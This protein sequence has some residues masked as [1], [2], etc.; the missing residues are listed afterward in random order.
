LRHLARNQGSTLIES[1]QDEEPH[2]RDGTVVWSTQSRQALKTP[3]PVRDADAGMMPGI[4]GS[5]LGAACA[6]STERIF[7]VTIRQHGLQETLRCVVYTSRL[8]LGHCRPMSR[9]GAEQRGQDGPVACELAK[10]GSP[11]IYRRGGRRSV[12]MKSGRG[13]FWGAAQKMSVE[14][15]RSKN[16][17]PPTR[18]DGSMLKL[19]QGAKR[20]PRGML[21][22]KDQREIAAWPGDSHGARLHLAAAHLPSP[23]VADDEFLGK[24]ADLSGRTRRFKLL[25]SD[26]HAIMCMVTRSGRP[27][28]W[29]L[30]FN[31]RGWEPKAGT[32]GRPLSLANHVRQS[33]VRGTDFVPIL[34]A[35]R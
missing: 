17:P 2:A 10:A 26:N 23:R 18:S 28:R 1:D 29:L 34:C 25:A 32:G 16:R 27:D 8:T 14:P 15:E 33:E 4:H 5:P 11:V 20:G 9:S 19:S 12:T 30:D 6:I 3:R 21:P 35:V 13:L 31:R 24:A 22:L 7:A